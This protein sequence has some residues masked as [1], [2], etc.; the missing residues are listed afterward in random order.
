MLRNARLFFAVC[1]ACF[2]QPISYY[3]SFSSINQQNDLTLFSTCMQLEQY[4]RSPHTQNAWRQFVLQLHKN[5]PKTNKK[6]VEMTKKLSRLRSINYWLDNFFLPAWHKYNSRPE[7]LAL[8]LLKKNDLERD[9]LEEILFKQQRLNLIKT[10]NWKLTPQASR[11]WYMLKEQIIPFFLTSYISKGEKV[12][13]TKRAIYSFARSFAN[14]S[15]LSRLAALTTMQNLVSILDKSMR[16]ATNNYKVAI[17]RE[18]IN[19]LSHWKTLA[20]LKERKK[21]SL[22]STPNIIA[23]A[24]GLYEYI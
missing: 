22:L 14:M 20:P 2:Y 17:E 6:L 24:Y 3:P 23:K 5:S 1:N 11:Q 8:E 10:D 21:M 15:Q 7:Q 18:C 19:L 13:G 16:H 9:F 4:A 12:E